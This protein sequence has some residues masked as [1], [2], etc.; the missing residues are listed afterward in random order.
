MNIY[1]YLIFLLFLKAHL[2][3]CRHFIDICLKPMEVLCGQ[4]FGKGL[5]WMALKD[6][7]R[8][9]PGDPVDTTPSFHCRGYRFN[10]TGCHTDQPRVFKNMK[11]RCRKILKDHALFI[12]CVNKHLNA[13]IVFHAHVYTSLVKMTRSF[14]GAHSLV[15]RGCVCGILEE[16]KTTNSKI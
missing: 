1:R 9:F 10:L 14:Q 12:H 5:D 4:M 6:A 3:Y 2:N 8:H 13:F 15:G 7:L 16:N 11:K